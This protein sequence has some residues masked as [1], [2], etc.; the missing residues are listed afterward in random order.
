MA[1]ATSDT[2]LITG[3]AG[4]LGSYV[5]QRLADDGFAHRVNP[6]KAEYDLTDAQPGGPTCSMRSGPT[7]SCTWR[8]RSA[9]SALTR[10]T[11]AGSSTPT[12][13]WA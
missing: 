8:P 3:G 11:P 2:L 1:I 5:N 13:R 10:R 4:F 12:W 6:R 7:P 9:A